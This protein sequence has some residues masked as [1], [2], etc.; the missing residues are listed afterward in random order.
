MKRV[1]WWSSEVWGG[2]D[3]IFG[4]GFILLLS[5]VWL[6]SVHI[7]F[8]FPFI[9]GIVFVGLSTYHANRRYWALK[10]QEGVK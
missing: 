1:S 4:I 6:W 2:W 8:L 10:R 3:W 7:L 9:L 5:T